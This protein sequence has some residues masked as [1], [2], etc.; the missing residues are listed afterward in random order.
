MAISVMIVLRNIDFSPREIAQRLH[1]KRCRWPK[2]S[3]RRVSSL[4]IF[5]AIRRAS[6][7]PPLRHERKTVR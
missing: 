5:S 2:V 1:C 3:D 7:L 6:S 4:A